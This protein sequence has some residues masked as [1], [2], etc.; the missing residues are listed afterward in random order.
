MAINLLQKLVAELPNWQRVVVEA[1]LNTPED[2]LEVH[3]LDGGI[4]FKRLVDD[5]K[6]KQG[7]AGVLAPESL[8]Q[9]REDKACLVPPNHGQ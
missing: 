2:R 5:M 4:C 6:S 9:L 1:L 3:L 8:D 7:G